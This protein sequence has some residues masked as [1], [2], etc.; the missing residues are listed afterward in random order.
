MKICTIRAA[1]RPD[2]KGEAIIVN[3]RAERAFNINK[4]SR[5]LKFR[6]RACLTLRHNDDAGEDGTERES[7]LQLKHHMTGLTMSDKKCPRCGR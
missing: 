1:K 3:T 4:L 7:V 5:L 6:Q 2:R